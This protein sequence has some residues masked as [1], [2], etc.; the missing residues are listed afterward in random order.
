MNVITTVSLQNGDFTHNAQVA[1]QNK[2][3]FDPIQLL[4]YQFKLRLIPL[5]KRSHCQNHKWA[6]PLRYKLHVCIFLN[7]IEF[8][9]LTFCR[10]CNYQNLR[11]S[12]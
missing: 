8:K 5:L 10:Q 9:L 4:T 3:T 7:T 12:G 1:I 6:I 2:I 11:L